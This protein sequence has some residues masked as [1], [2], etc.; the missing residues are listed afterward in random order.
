MSW[1]SLFSRFGYKSNNAEA[2][3]TIGDAYRAVFLG[4]PDK[5]QQQMV[6]ADLRAKCYVDQC[7]AE[8]SSDEL[9]R[10]EGMRAAF[11]LIS[12]HLVMEA[13]DLEALRVAARREA[14]FSSATNTRK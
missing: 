4:S 13:S 11:G 2:Q 3:I 1:A 9:W 6:L 14:A 12:S 8:I 7:M 10:I 5:E